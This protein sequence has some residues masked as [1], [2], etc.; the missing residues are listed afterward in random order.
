ML[1]LPRAK[2]F[3][4]LPWLWVPKPLGFAGGYPCCCGCDCPVCSGGCPR[5][6]QV[7]IAGIVNGS[8]GSCGT[9]NGTFTCDWSEYALGGSVMRC[10]WEYLFG[11]T[12]CTSGT[13]QDRIVVE[14]YLLTGTYWL[15]VH[16][17][18]IS[19]DCLNFGT[20]WGS[21]QDC[22]AWS[23]LSLAPLGTGVCDDWTT[24]ATCTVTAI[25]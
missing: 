8:C 13:P 17:A 24:P 25:E 21:A 11:S 4:Q 12:I 5:Q 14:H 20:S 18:R 16:A 6:M 22:M 19:G 9:F 23:S 7:S 3:I 15:F 2:S 1:Y 10:F